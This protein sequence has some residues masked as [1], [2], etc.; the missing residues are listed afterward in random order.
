MKPLLDRG[1]QAAGALKKQKAEKNLR[2]FW[3]WAARNRLE[4]VVIQ[5]LFQFTALLGFQR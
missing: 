5:L 1:D 4:S 3:Y 2:F